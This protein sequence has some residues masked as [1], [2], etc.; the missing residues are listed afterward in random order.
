MRAVL[1]LTIT[2]LL[3][4]PLVTAEASFTVSIEEPDGH[5]FSKE[6]VERTVI[7]KGNALRNTEAVSSWE[8]LVPPAII[9]RGK[10]KISLKSS[11]ENRFKVCLQMPEVKRRAKLIWRIRLFLDGK[12]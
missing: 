5:F 12:C 1:F 11:S 7:I 6:K 2:I 4:L 3:A 10:K 8:T 9:E